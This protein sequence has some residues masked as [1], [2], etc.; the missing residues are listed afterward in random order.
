MR[1]L[2]PLLALPLRAPLLL[3]LFGVSLYL[4]S[5]W[6]LSLPQLSEQFSSPTRLIWLVECLHALLVVVICTMPDLL[7]LRISQLMAA[8]RVVSLVVSLLLVTLAGLY[9]LHLNVLSNV[10]IL[11]PAV[12]LA[13]LDLARIRVVPSSFT[14]ALALSLLVMVGLL[15]GRW[16]G[17]LG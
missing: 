8:S 15:T 17:S 16:L 4:G 9:L 11:A 10:L 7:L 14:S 13:R 5:H 6:S 1:R 3:L 12:L 2:L